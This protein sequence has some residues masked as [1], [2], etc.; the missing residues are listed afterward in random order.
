MVL[1]L[2][3]LAQAQDVAS[4][5]P[6]LQRL[7][8]GIQ[9]ME[10]EQVQITD[11][12]VGIVFDDGV[13]VGHP[14]FLQAGEDLAV[15]GMGDPERVAD[16]D[17]FVFDE[18]GQVVQRDEAPDNAPV[19]HFVAPETGVYEV[20]V[21]IG[22]SRPGWELGFFSLAMGYGTAGAPV[23]VLETFDTVEFAS[24]LLEEEGYQALHV[25][26]ET[27]AAGQTAFVQARIDDWSHCIA[28]AGAS[29]SRTRRLDLYVGDPGDDGVAHD[30]RNGEMAFAEFTPNPSGQ[31]MFAMEARKLA[32]GVT[33]THAVVVLACRDE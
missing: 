16:L 33:D 28:I 3:G 18:R 32:R 20:R 1:A 29:P 30:R 19:L 15:L 14:V 31:W 13:G 25:E 8:V 7:A 11:M 17:L 27:I 2:L 23:S 10:A 4:L 9:Q 12:N 24:G 21:V 26:W 22:R 6:V 5:E